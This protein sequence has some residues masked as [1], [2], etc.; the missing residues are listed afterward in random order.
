MERR[1]LGT[2]RLVGQW[3]AGIEWERF[4]VL[5]LNLPKTILAMNEPTGE[6][7]PS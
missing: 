5:Q 1:L 7:E 2:V 6:L 3:T 4:P